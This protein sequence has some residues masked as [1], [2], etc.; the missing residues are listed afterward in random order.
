[1]I[2]ENIGANQSPFKMSNREFTRAKLQA[3]ETNKKIGIKDTSVKGGLGKDAFLKL[4]VTELR[5]Q[6]PTKPM[7]DREFISQMAQFSSLEQMTNLNKEV[8]S[9][10]QSSRSSEAFSLLGKRIESFN[11]VNNI[12]ISGIVNSVQYNKNQL[13]LMVD[14]REVSMEHV[15][16]VHNIEKNTENNNS[17]NENIKVENKDTRAK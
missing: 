3:D 7:E 16:S 1:M 8:Q 6:D 13:M 5:H 9:L 15:H 4:L 14:G 2:T 17:T 11:P 10:I 12:K